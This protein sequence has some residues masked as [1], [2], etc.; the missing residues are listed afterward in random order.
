MST[1]KAF[2]KPARSRSASR[3]AVKH[4]KIRSLLTLLGLLGW[5]R[6]EPELLA[7]LTTKEPLLLDDT[8]ASLRY[9]ATPTVIWHSE[10]VLVDELDRTRPDLLAIFALLSNLTRA[11]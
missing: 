8:Q 6:L 7:A 1:R 5:E 2:P 10:V 11:L 4:R 3:S 9:I